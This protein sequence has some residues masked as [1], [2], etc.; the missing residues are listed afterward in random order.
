MTEP[1]VPL[2]EVFIKD[3]KR[4]PADGL[5]YRVDEL[6][7]NSEEGSSD[8]VVSSEYLIIHESQ[9]DPTFRRILVQ[10]PDDNTPSTCNKLVVILRPIAVGNTQPIFNVRR[11][12]VH[13]PSGCKSRPTIVA[14]VGSDRGGS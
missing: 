7:I 13:S 2:F 9:G 12:K 1:G 11:D 4:A 6:T 8:I 14:S 3:G 10:I 5:R